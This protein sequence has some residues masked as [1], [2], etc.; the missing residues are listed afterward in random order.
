MT[1]SKTKREEEGYWGKKLISAN[2]EY[3]YEMGLRVPS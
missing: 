1:I 3:I 2:W